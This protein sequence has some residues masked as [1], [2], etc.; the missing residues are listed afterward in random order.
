MTTI[1]LHARLAPHLPYIPQRTAS[2]RMRC[3]RMSTLSRPHSAPKFVIPSKSAAGK[4]SEGSAFACFPPN[5]SLG[6]LHL[7][8][9]RVSHSTHGATVLLVFPTKSLKLLL[10]GST[11]VRINPEFFKSN[12]SRNA[13][14]P[15]LAFS[16]APRYTRLFCKS[17][18]IS[19]SSLG[20]RSL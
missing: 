1:A 3:L 8:H 15:R 5:V 12:F 10:S 7:A 14:R 9:S 4:C 19:F 2:V 16:R 17:S 13:R 18:R 6:A 20:W 11:V